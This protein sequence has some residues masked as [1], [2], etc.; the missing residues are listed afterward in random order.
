MSVPRTAPWET[1]TPPDRTCWGPQYGR[2][3][4]PG[5]SESGDLTISP[6]HVPPT[7]PPCSPPLHLEGLRLRDGV[8]IRGA[9]TDDT[10]VVWAPEAPGSLDQLPVWTVERTRHPSLGGLEG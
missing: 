2:G 4:G 9:T 3:S 6:T 8:G 7:R 1:L 5:S 10:V